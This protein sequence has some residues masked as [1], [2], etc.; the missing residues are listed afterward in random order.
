MEEDFNF[1]IHQLNAHAGARFQHFLI[2]HVTDLL[3][4]VGS[5][6]SH[7]SSDRSSVGQSASHS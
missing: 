4:R 3:Q 5:C 1:E 2:G 6:L 7:S